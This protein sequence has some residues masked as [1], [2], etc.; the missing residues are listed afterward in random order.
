[1]LREA[2]KFS[3][4]GSDEEAAL[5]KAKEE[6]ELVGDIIN[7]RKRVSDQIL[8]VVQIQQSLEGDNTY[9]KFIFQDWESFQLK[10]FLFHFRILLNHQE[11]ILLKEIA[12]SKMQKFIIFCSTISFCSP[13][14]PQTLSK[15]NINIKN[16]IFSPKR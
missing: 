5:T 2:I 9:V 14:P 1:M 15:K 4:V 10:S 12:C 6:I 13:H 3:V 8:K 7:E 16:I 11:D